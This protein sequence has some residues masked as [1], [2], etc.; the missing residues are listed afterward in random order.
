M[1]EAVTAPTTVDRTKLL[2]RS[3]I[4]VEAPWLVIAP[5]G[6]P[7]IRL[8]A[9]L[10]DRVE[11][12][13]R[14]PTSALVVSGLAT[15][16]VAAAAFSLVP[17]GVFA[18]A[19]LAYLAHERF[20]EARKRQR[21]R[22]LLLALGDLEVALHVADG[23]EAAK[24]VAEQLAPYTR[25]AP[26]TRP[27]VFEDAKRR[28]RAQ[29]EGRGEASARRELE[30]AL[31]VGSDVVFLKGDR[32]QVG[33]I[34]FPIAEVR[35]YALR[36]ANLPLTGGRLLQAAMGLLVV[37]AEERAAAGEDIALLSKRVADY[38]AWSGHTAGR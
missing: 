35:E 4:G 2:P 25:D 22:D 34:A 30:H 15:A 36:G 23:P 33:Q 19:G 9:R 32:L 26:I 37:A 12:I 3:G 18:C 38:E 20:S 5:P 17:G 29:A 11:L 1:A 27:E 21:N 13:G 8:D 7:I 10:L 16:G 28:I 31:L 6:N 14:S 24:G